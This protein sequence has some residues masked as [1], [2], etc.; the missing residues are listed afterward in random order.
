MVEKGND[1]Q[2]I[3]EDSSKLAEQYTFQKEQLE[4]KNVQVYYFINYN[5]AYR[6]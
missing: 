4:E 3:K 2:K 1:M 6:Y 5:I